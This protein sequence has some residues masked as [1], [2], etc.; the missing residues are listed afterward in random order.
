MSYEA[1]KFLH[2]VG[3][4]MLFAALGGLAAL[5]SA[6]DRPL[7]TGLY[8]FLHGVALVFILVAGFGLLTR[9]ELSAP[10]SWP[11]WVW[12]KLLVWVLLGA[13]LVLLKK[14]GKSAGLVLLVLLFLGAIA[15]SAA[16]F[17]F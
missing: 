12:I 7:G 15:V 1:Y 2:L 17:K 3:I 4:L 5:R 10:G 11:L 8:N 6:V 9:L 16:I 14:A 13:G